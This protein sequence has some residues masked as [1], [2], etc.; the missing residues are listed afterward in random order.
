MTGAAKSSKDHEVNVRAQPSIRDVAALAGVGVSSVSRVLS[1]HP[2]VSP[3]MRRKVTKAVEQLQY[4]PDFL[5]QS[6]R[7]G[8][9]MSVGFVLS[10]IA[11]PLFSEIVKGASTVLQNAGYLTLLTNSEGNPELDVVNI[12]LLTQRRVDGLIL[13]TASEDHPATLDLLR[14]IDIP[15]VFLDRDPPLGLAVNR[16]VSDH[17]AGMTTAV[18]HLVDLGHRRIGL[19]SG[20]PMRPSRE[21]RRALE[22]VF[23]ERD[24]PPTYEVSDGDFSA[25]HGAQATHEFL[26]FSHPPTAIIAGG[27]QMLRGALRAIRERKLQIGRDLSFVSCD[28]IAIAEFYHPPIAVV[29]RDTE[30]LGRAA[31]ELLLDS[32][33]DRDTSPNR[34]PRTEMMLTTEFVIRPSCAPVSQA[35]NSLISI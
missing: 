17:R 1:S 25:Q 22:E 4:Q 12:R 3:A 31:A 8:A 34:T 7:R 15:M 11:N 20:R 14:R 23:A 29:R 33:L 6:L 24:L 21:R 10:D 26:S 35:R 13:S 32:L 16:V 9:S 5:A 19:L 27:N 28:E 2:D 18:E 30:E